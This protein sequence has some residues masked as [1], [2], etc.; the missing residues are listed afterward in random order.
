[1]NLDPPRVSNFSPP[2]L[3][4]VIFGGLK[5]QILEDSGMHKIAIS[6][7]KSQLEDLVSQVIQPQGFCLLGDLQPDKSLERI[8]RLDALRLPLAPCKIK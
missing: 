8:Q 5:F 3:F 6:F 1:M 4:L 7:K 2:G